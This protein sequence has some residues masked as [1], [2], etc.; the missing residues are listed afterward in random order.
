LPYSGLGLTLLTAFGFAA[1]AQQAGRIGA[2]KSSEENIQA[3]RGTKPSHVAKLRPAQVDWSELV[4]IQAEMPPKA[5]PVELPKVDGS[6]GT[7]EEVP[8]VEAPSSVRRKDN[9]LPAPDDSGHAAA[10]PGCTGFPVIPPASLST[11]GQPD[12]PDSFASLFFPPNAAGGVGPDHLMVMAPNF[13]LI[14]DRLG[15]TISTIDTLT[16]WSPTLA[17]SVTYCRLDYDVVTDRWIATARGG[18]GVGACSILFAISDTSDPTLGWDFY[19]ISADPGLT[20]FPDGLKMGYNATWVAVCADMYTGAPATAGSRLYTFD[21]QDALMGSTTATTFSAGF[22]TATT[23]LFNAAVNFRNVPVR[24]MDNSIADLWI[25]NSRATSGTNVA[26]QIMSITGTGPLPVVQPTL[27]SAFGGNLS[28]MF[29]PINYSNVRQ[30]VF[31][32]GDAR[33]I[34]PLQF[35]GNFASTRARIADAVVRNGN[36]FVV[37]NA[38]LPGPN[39]A[40]P[41]SNGVCFYE[42]DASLPFGFD[43][44]SGIGPFVQN[45][46]ISDGINTTCMFPSIAVN[47]AN[48]VLIGFS[49][50]DLTKNVEAAYMMRLG[51]DPLNTMGP[52]TLLKAGESSW[53]QTTPPATLAP[54]GFYSSSAIDPNDDETLWTLQPY[55]A[56]RVGVADADSRWG[57]WWGRLG[58]CESGPIMITDDPDDFSGCAGTNLTLSVSATGSPLFYQWR[59]DGMDI[60]GANSSTLDFLP[61]VPTDS[62]SYDCVVSGCT[63]V[64]SAAAIVDLG[65]P[66]I[67]TQPVDFVSEPHEPAGFFVVA[68]PLLGTLSYQWFHGA[69]P[70]GTNSNLLLIADV[71]FADFGDYT[72]VVSDSCGSITTTVARLLPGVKTKNVD[73]ADLKH[74]IYD[75]P[76]SLTACIGSTAEF[77]V[78]YGPTTANLVWRHNSIPIVPPQ[79]DDTLVISPVTALDAGV[80][81]VQ[82]IDGANTKTSLPA[83]LTTIDVPV[84][85]VQPGP[86]SGSASPGDDVTYSVTVSAGGTVTYQWEKRPATPFAVF[87]PMVGHTTSTLG[88]ENVTSNDSGAYR[89]RI[90]NECGLIR[91]RI[92]NLV[93]I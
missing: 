51:S 70:V 83:L 38:G 90:Q 88:L 85:T 32:V 89:C 78:V 45:V 14:Q 73:E 72:C 93:V 44:G 27:G 82:V 57:T 7:F 92:C 11:I 34:D 47:C 64:C 13:T 8:D 61:L 6:V 77:S 63:T 49:R 9:I 22:V 15:N 56:T 41:T 37:H 39:N 52:T 43:I 67:T 91:T 86:V 2:P 75:H 81:D 26:W 55:A 42:L 66:T 74:K 76:Q 4:R 20:T 68:T 28:L 17:P 79:T 3:A 23:G 48:D 58:T 18:A 12:G 54:W 33:F 25:L 5:V 40:S 59:K 24:S 65:E 50:S 31:Q 80:Y 87:S 35:D 69:T 1:S 21:L 53:W 60:L 36:I 29:V 10:A 16:F 30:A 84:I 46:Q 71:T 62:G 19:S